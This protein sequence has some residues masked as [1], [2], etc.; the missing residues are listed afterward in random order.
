MKTY[1]KTRRGI[2]WL[3]LGIFREALLLCLLFV[4][5]GAAGFALIYFFRVP[6]V[7]D[8]FDRKLAQSSVIYD[9]TGERVLYEIYGE[10]HRKVL[11]HEAIPDV[12]RK[13][14]IAAEDDTFY[15]HPGFDVPSMLRALQK[16]LESG[17]VVQGGSTITQQV[18][19]IFYLDNERTIARKLNEIVLAWKIE[20]HYPKDRILDLYLNSI[21]Y[22]SNAYGIETAAE[23]FFGKPAADLTIDEAAFLAALPKATTYY[24]PYRGREDELILRQRSIIRH[25]EELGL[26][27]ERETKNALLTDTFA[28]VLPRRDPVVAPH[29]VFSVL[30]ELEYRYGR[31]FLETGGLRVTTTLDMD[32]QKEAEKIVTEG[33]A[34]NERIYGGENAALVAVG[35]GTGEMLAMVGS[36]DFFDTR[37]DGEV[38]VATR[39]RQPGS[40]FKPFVYARAFEEGFQPETRILD[41][42]VNFGPDGSGRDYIP[43]NYSGKSYGLLTMRQALSMSLNVPAVQTLNVVGVDDAI[44][45]ATRLGITTLTDP[46]RYG[47]SL[48]LGGAEVKPI[49]MASAFSV[50][51]ADGIR[52]ETYDIVS[53]RKNGKEIFS[54]EGDPG[55]RVLDSDIARKI[56]SILSDN[57]ARTP[58]FGPRSPLAYPVGGVAAKTGTTQGFRD[59]WTVGFS[60]DVSVAVWAGNNDGRLM[61]SGADGVFVAAPIWRQFMDYALTRYPPEPFLAYEPSVERDP[62]LVA[63]GQVYASVPENLSAPPGKDAPKEKGGKKK[64]TKKS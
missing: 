16:N 24:S 21:P 28:N 59:A 11:P 29:F 47:L 62:R 31:E 57:A 46:K 19:R 15:R 5:G 50:F 12:V 52:H 17:R 14:T 43:Q 44:D 35:V 20:R 41:A 32:L 13:A 2:K 27:A 48:V 8:L 6:D 4:F 36:R 34:R 26:I 54:M 63:K 64:K 30:E 22:G 55:K 37:I 3:I 61:K 60:K 1:T 42:P 23:S 45:L 39:A 56:G 49:D 53:I 40:A 33:A 58:V 38:N 18:A 7:G 25:M 51:G 9:R 10:E